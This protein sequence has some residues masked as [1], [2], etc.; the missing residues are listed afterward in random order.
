MGPRPGSAAAKNPPLSPRHMAAARRRDRLAAQ[1][2]GA[3]VRS[4][5][6]SA[7]TN[8]HVQ[9]PNV[10]RF[11]SSGTAPCIR[12][13]VWRRNAIGCDGQ[14]VTFETKV[15]PPFGRLGISPLMPTDRLYTSTIKREFFSCL[16]VD[17]G[18]GLLTPQQFE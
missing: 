4:T 16:G 14:Q 6:R 15:S 13:V 1:S 18:A 10:G 11:P 7:I 17:E 8:H 9:P 3:Q 12:R 2:W 5:R